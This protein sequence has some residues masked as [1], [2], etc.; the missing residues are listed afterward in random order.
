[1]GKDY[2]TIALCMG[3]FCMSGEAT[4]TEMLPIG[5]NPAQCDLSAGCHCIVQ[6]LVP[7]GPVRRECI[8]N[9]GGDCRTSTNILVGFRSKRLQCKF[10]V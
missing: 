3:P 4:A 6:V 10:W 5:K 8:T 2:L 1:M 7:Q 9:D